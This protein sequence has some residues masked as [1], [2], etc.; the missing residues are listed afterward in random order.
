MSAIVEAL[1][2]ADNYVRLS[3]AGRWMY[4]DEVV[5]EWVVMKSGRKGCIA[6]TESELRAIS[7]LLDGL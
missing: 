3:C 6:R 4:W 2:D 5:G 1:K 7:A